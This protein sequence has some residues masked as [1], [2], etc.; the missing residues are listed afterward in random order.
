MAAI[1]VAAKT[2]GIRRAFFLNILG[3]SFSLN[4][5]SPCAAFEDSPGSS[6]IDH[7]LL[8][9]ALFWCITVWAQKIPKVRHGRPMVSIPATFSPLP[10]L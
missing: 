9:I 1:A 6:W 7:T 4:P 2:N 10:L 3:V 5:V 8:S